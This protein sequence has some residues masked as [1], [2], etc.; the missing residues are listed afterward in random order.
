MNVFSQQLYP[1]KLLVIIARCLK[2]F[3]HISLSLPSY[4]LKHPQKRV[5]L[6][7]RVYGEKI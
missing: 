7:M 6:S 1:A 4:S 2:D 3:S 5:F